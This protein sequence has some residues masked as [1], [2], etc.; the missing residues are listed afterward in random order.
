MELDFNSPWEAA[1]TIGALTAWS[2]LASGCGSA[3][4]SGRRFFNIT[5]QASQVNFTNG[6]LIGGGAALAAATTF[7]LGHEIF[8]RYFPCEDTNDYL[9]KW[10][11][12]SFIPL[13]AVPYFSRCSLEAAITLV[14]LAILGAFAKDAT[15]GILPD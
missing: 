10:S 11:W 7:V 5:F 2:A 14:G 9:V 13:I 12:A 8:K 6:V 4:L 3:V 15:V 1:Q